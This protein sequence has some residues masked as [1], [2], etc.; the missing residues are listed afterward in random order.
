MLL[1]MVWTLWNTDA[2]PISF[3]SE[4]IVYCLECE[5]KDNIYREEEY[6]V[7]TDDKNSIDSY[8]LKLE[9][10]IYKYIYKNDFE[11]YRSGLI[12]IRNYNYFKLNTTYIYIDKLSLYIHPLM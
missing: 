12:Y 4:D 6:F 5:T 3:L 11:C 10:Y 8:S 2:N 7:D 1:A 9:I